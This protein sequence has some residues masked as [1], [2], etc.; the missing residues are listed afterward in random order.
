MGETVID[1]FEEEECRF[2]EG[3]EDYF[4]G[5][6]DLRVSILTFFKNLEGDKVCL[7]IFVGD[8]MRLS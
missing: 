2:G 6:N 3:K 8:G 4:L 7:S 1:L 5:D